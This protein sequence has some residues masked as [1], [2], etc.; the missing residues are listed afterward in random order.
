MSSYRCLLTS[1][2]INQLILNNCQRSNQGHI[3]LILN[4]NRLQH[5]FP[6]KVL[7]H[8]IVG[9]PIQSCQ[10]KGEMLRKRRNIIS[11]GVCE[12]SYA[13]NTNCHIYKQHKVFVSPCYV[14]LF[15]LRD[16]L[17]A[18]DQGTEELSALSA[19]NALI[20]LVKTANV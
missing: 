9:T 12:L 10:G 6:S 14:Y 2:E 19:Q 7:H 4:L 13:N 16:I 20:S 11:L 17:I 5:L 15:L 8:Q 18:P 1:S 3:A